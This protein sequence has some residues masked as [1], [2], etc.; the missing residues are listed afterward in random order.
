MWGRTVLHSRRMDPGAPGRAPDADGAVDVVRQTPTDRG[1]D[2]RIAELRRAVAQL[3]RELAEYPVELSD[4]KAA[5]DELA[6]LGQLV[7]SGSPE[8]SRLRASL[9]LIA[10]AVGSVSALAS[11]LSEVRKAV[12]LFSGPPQ[13]R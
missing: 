1:E 7:D 12:E 6:A 2:P 8:I 4:R 13:R 9:L 3:R 11:A 5:D 10:G